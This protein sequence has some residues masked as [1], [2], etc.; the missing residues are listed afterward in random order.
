VH[1]KVSGWTFNSRAIWVWLLLEFLT[2]ST[3]SRLNP[4]NHLG[5]PGHFVAQAP[6]ILSL[7][8]AHLTV[9]SC[10]TWFFLLGSFGFTTSSYQVIEDHV[11]FK[12]AKLMLPYL[13]RL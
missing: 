4:A 11:L 9:Q 10:L 7:L 8:P 2:I 6:S 3:A 12:C 13:G 1:A 5:P